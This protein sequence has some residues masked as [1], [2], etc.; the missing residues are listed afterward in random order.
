MGHPLTPYR[1]LT[2]SP[3]SQDN[4]NALVRDSLD[5]WVHGTGSPFELLLADADWTI[6][7]SSPL[8]KTYHGKQAFLHEVIHPFNARMRSPLIPT[9]RG[10]Y[11]DADMVIILFDAA[12]TAA[13]GIAYHNTYTWYFKMADGKLQRHCVLRHPGIRCR[14]AARATGVNAPLRALR[15]PWAGAR[16][17]FPG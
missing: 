8:S 5:R 4:D 13:D 1:N 15:Y 17:D 16:G 3:T 2:E 7:G 14:L 9:V 12:A 6:V 10:I 11:A